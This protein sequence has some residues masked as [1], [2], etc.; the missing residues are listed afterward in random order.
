MTG[1][2]V[3]LQADA[4]PVTVHVN[5]PVGAPTPFASVT[6]AVKMRGWPTVGELGET[7]ITIVGVANPTETFIFEE[8][9]ET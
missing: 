9:T 6:V 5:E 1:P 4:A 8:V 2:V 7:P 3:E